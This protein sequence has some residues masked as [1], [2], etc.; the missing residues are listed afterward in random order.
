MRAIFA[1]VL[2]ATALSTGGC[3]TVPADAY[4]RA[5]YRHV[6][7]E[8]A[9]PAAPRGDPRPRAWCGWF[10]RQMYGVADKT[11]NAAAKWA[12]YGTNAGG[13][14]VGAVIVWRHHVGEIVPGSCPA[15]EVMLHSGN[16]LNQVCTRCFPTRGAIAYRYP[17]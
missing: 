9:A 14:Q 6:V 8:A 16:D 3:V 17:R 1:A 4:S 2:F 11:Y 13:P 10:M 5:G 12:H 15:R 7:H